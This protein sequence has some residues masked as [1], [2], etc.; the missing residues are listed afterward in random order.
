MQNSTV[1]YTTVQYSTV[2]YSTLQYSTLNRLY[3]AVIK[4]CTLLLMK[5][6][7]FL[8]YKYSSQAEG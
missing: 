4:S 5:L 6:P 8:P 7:H 1:K 2:Q 3:S